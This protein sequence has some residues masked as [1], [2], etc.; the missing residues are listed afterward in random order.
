MSSLTS[1]QNQFV[2]TLAK[3][4]GWDPKA[5][6]AWALA[7]ESGGAAQSRQ[8]QGNQNWLNIG[9]FDSGPAGWAKTAFKDPVQAANL[10]TKFL[11]GQWG[12]ASSSIKN[13]SGA[14]TPGDLL[15]RIANSDWA[16]SHYNG[17]RDL[18]SLY[19]Q[20]GGSGNFSASPQPASVSPVSTSAAP[21]S[22][23]TDQ[24]SALL[25]YLMQSNAAQA[26]GHGVDPAYQQQQ[27][28]TMLQGGSTPFGAGKPGVTIA[29]GV[30]SDVGNGPISPTAPRVL[31][32]A[33]KYLGT[34]YV[35]GG[36]NPSTG[37]DCSGFVQ[38]LYGQQGIKLPRTTYEQIKVGQHVDR[39]HLQPGD[40]IFFSNA[41]DVH[42]EGMYIG[43]NQFIHAPHTGDVIKISSLNDAYYAKQF[44]GGRRVA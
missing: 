31:Q 27:L 44:A 9:Y 15:S 18:Q 19:K 14:R 16:S 12:G 10:T 22:G 6:A 21:A 30:Q 34:K 11:R 38:W 32:L 24:R 23:A 5:V 26:S 4:F 36:S 17:G 1:G 8:A 28:L 43:N 39:G 13:I 42:H 41:G 2:N 7:E 20:M 25:Q 37:F 33:K 3:N 40:I 35:W 29:K